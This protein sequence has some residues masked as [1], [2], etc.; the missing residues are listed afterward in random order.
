MLNKDSKVGMLLAALVKRPMSGWRMAL[1]IIGAAGLVVTPSW[2]LVFRHLSLRGFD[3]ATERLAALSASMP[4]ESAPRTSQPSSRPAE[5]AA[6]KPVSGAVETARPS[7]PGGFRPVMSQAARGP[8]AAPAAASIA[9]QPAGGSVSAPA[10]E[11]R[12]AAPS[13]PLPRSES[14]RPL[15]TDSRAFAGRPVS[16]PLSPFSRQNKA[17]REQ[18]AEPVSFK[19]EPQVKMPGPTAVSGAGH[20]E[21]TPAAAAAPA[22]AAGVASGQPI[23]EN[24]AQSG[25]QAPAGSGAAAGSASGSGDA[26]GGLELT[27]LSAALGGAADTAMAGGGGSAGGGAGGSGIDIRAAMAD[28]QKCS[29]S[30]A[31]YTPLVQK[32]SA[33]MV[34]LNM[35]ALSCG[36]TIRCSFASH[37][38]CQPSTSTDPTEKWWRRHYEGQCA[39]ARLHCAVQ[40][41]CQEVNDLSCQQLHGCPMTATKPCNPSPCNY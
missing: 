12:D 16:V 26:A 19:G 31:Y 7:A 15:P 13:Q 9:A 41:K 22:S 3:G 29:Q 17:S 30:T 1:L 11:G 32:A 20:A 40:K 2:F 36:P 24:A 27:G 34:A 25:L 33:E 14:L 5:Q 37:Q 18:L 6:L 35:Q 38:V 4:P 21:A 23:G 10:L 28:G 39:C 8:G